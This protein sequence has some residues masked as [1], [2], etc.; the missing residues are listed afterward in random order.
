MRTDK[1]LIISVTLSMLLFTFTY[2]AWIFHLYYNVFE[3]P[4]GKN[5]VSNYFIEYDSMRNINIYSHYLFFATMESLALLFRTDIGGIIT[6]FFPF[7]TLI[8]WPYLMG[9]YSKKMGGSPWTAIFFLTFG[10]Y[11][12]HY[13]DIVSIWGQYLSYTCFFMAFISWE[14]KKKYLAAAFAI[15]SIGYHF[16]T[17]CI[18]AILLFA[19]GIKR[20]PFDTLVSSML[21]IMLISSFS[22]FSILDFTFYAQDRTESGIIKQT[23][24]YETMLLFINPIIIIFALIGRKFRPLRYDSFI[25]LLYLIGLMSHNSRALI[26]ALPFICHYASVGFECLLNYNIAESAWRKERFV[27]II[28]IILIILVYFR[29]LSFLLLDSMY[30]E[31]KTRGLYLNY[32]ESAERFLNILRLKTP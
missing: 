16:Y 10:T 14:M 30:E 12:I 11:H 26:Y 1:T 18:Y 8:L 3:I 2:T 9:I 28:F 17:I 4:F 29:Y 20:H 6:Q 7:L 19:I 21:F 32:G 31:I 24:L 23:N 27:Y 15:F 22:G 13:A 5:D 25:C